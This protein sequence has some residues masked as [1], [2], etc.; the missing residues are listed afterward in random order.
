[1]MLPTT[2]D[3]RTQPVKEFNSCK[4]TFVGI[5]E[6]VSA[7]SSTSVPSSEAVSGDRCDS[8]TL[9]A[10]PSGTTIGDPQYRPTPH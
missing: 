10:A 7:R 8:F 9:T 5:V 3:I 1:M 6:Y 4:V 2:T